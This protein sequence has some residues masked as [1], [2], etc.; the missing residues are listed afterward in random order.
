MSK[1]LKWIYGNKSEHN[2]FYYNIDEVTVANEWNPQ[3]TDFYSQGGLNF[4]N[5]ENALRWISRGDTLYDVIIP[6]D[7]EVIN[8]EN[9]KTPNGIYRSNK[10]IVTNPRKVSDELTLELYKKSSMPELT[11][12]K[13]IS[14]LAMKGCYNTCI[15]IIKDRVD[16][17]N[18]DLVIKEYIDFNRPGHSEHM[19]KKT[20]YNILEVLKE[21][22]SELLISLTINK[23]PLIKKLTS[24]KVINIT[25]QTGSGKSTYA[26]KY[27]NNDDYLVIDT[28]EFI[29]DNMFNISKGIA[30]E[31]GI[32]LRKK[33]KKMPT[34]ESNFDNIYNDILDYCSK[35]QKTI[36]I[37][38]AMFHAIKNINILKGEIIIIRTCINTC[39]KRCIDRYKKSNSN[40]TDEE[41]KEYSKKKLAIYKWYKGSN[42]LIKRINFN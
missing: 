40:Y 12:Y 29:S 13:T 21:I 22:Q 5:E 10:L 4:T 15:E 26:L 41:L 37:D 38:S 36:V 35:Y 2:N 3:S 24:D 31:I 30:R 28:D 23:E 42:D 16:K 27:V 33:Y 9:S 6:D 32:Y 14:A 25:G 20:W 17:N 34:L 19:D 8:V 1:F 18:I 39:Y 11:Y 7:A